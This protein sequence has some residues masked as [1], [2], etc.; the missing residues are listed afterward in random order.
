ML[1]LWLCYFLPS[2]SWSLKPPIHATAQSTIT[3]LHV[4]VA[5]NRWNLL[6]RSDCWITD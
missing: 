4:M 2:A 3:T 1:C 6:T 5:K